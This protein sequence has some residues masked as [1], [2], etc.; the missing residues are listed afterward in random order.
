MGTLVSEATIMR[1]LR[2]DPSAREEL[3]RVLVYTA[4][5]CAWC[6]QYRQTPKG[7][8]YLYLYGVEMD[9]GR[10]YDDGKAFCSL[11]CRQAYYG[12]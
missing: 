5:V 12:G 8:R 1:Y 2:R 3:Y 11:G 4:K 6:G 10:R 7:R 9:S